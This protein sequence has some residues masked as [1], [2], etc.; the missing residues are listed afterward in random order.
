M[1]FGLGVGTTAA[2]LSLCQTSNVLHFY[3]ITII[4][5]EDDVVL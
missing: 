4:L 1:D 2:L 3:K 5:E